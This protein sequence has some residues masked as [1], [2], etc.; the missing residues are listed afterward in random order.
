MTEPPGLP[1]PPPPQRRQPFV[2]PVVVEIGRLSEMTLQIS[3]GG[4]L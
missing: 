4:G 2:P 1:E 3:G